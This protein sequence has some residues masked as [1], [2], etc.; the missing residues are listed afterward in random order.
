MDAD[1]VWRAVQGAA[2]EAGRSA[3]AAAAR[4]GGAA[5]ARARSLAAAHNVPVEAVGAAAGAAVLL[6][7]GL[8]YFAATRAAASGAGRGALADG[9]GGAGGAGAAAAAG[10]HPAPPPMPELNKYERQLVGD[11]VD[12]SVLDSGFDDI[13][14]LDATIAAVEELVVYPLSHPHLYAHSA[15]ARSAAGVLLYGPPG[16]GKTLLAK[17]IAKTAAASFLSVNVANIQSKWFGETPKL[18]EAVFTLAR[19]AAPCVVFVDEVDGVLAARNDMDAQHVNTMKTKFMEM[20]DGLTTPAAAGGAAPAAAA[21]PAPGKAPGRDWVLVIGATNKPWALDPA[22]L[23]RM[24]RQLY[25]GL[26]DAPARASILRVLLRKE[27]ADGA[28]DVDAVAAATEGYSGS[29]LKELVRA[30]ALIPI[31]EEIAAARAAARAARAAGGGGAAPAPSDPRALVTADLLAATAA[32]K[33]TGVAASQ[34]R[35]AQAGSANSF[36]IGGPAG[37]AAGGR[38]GRAGTASPPSA[39]AA[40]PGG[41][42]AGG[43]APAGRA[44]TFGGDVPMYMPSHSLRLN[45]QALASAVESSAG[46]AAPKVVV[47]A[48]GGAPL[49][50]ADGRANTGAGAPR[51]AVG[52]VAHDSA[53]DMAH[54]HAHAGL[55]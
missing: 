6:V 7:G 35:F 18:V 53:H 2:A 3:A 10:A 52:K 16:T 8:A 31:R 42:D 33:P 19:K 13:G 39:A 14:G 50:A 27:K 30:A 11:M 43:D 26:P 5:A 15:A 21:A 46:P 32:V 24:P 37:G 20:W 48:G 12:P 22:V 34:Y 1:A 4:A 54:A 41:G 55:A 44:V 51:S 17:A 40:G 29:D 23:R 25:V 45:T 9:A 38:R 28:L 47:T 49:R 36:A